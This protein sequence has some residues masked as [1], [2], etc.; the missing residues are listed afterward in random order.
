MNLLIRADASVAIGT[1]HVMRCLALAQAW[2]DAGG[3]AAFAMAET[4]PAIGKRL[5]SEG[6]EIFRVA[7]DSGEKDDASQTIGLGRQ[8]G[9]RWIVVDGYQFSDEYQCVLKDAG[10]KVLFLDDYGH[11]NHYY[12]DLVLNQNVHADEAMYQSR[13]PHTRLL[14]GTRFCLLRRE[15][16]QWREWKRVI[17]PQVRK[18]LVSM[19]GSDA[20]NVTSK[21]LPALKSIQAEVIA[22]AGGSNPH[23]ESLEREAKSDVGFRLLKDVENMPALM[24]WAD[25]AVVAAGSICWEICVTGL[26]SILVVTASNQKDVAETLAR[27]EA[28]LALDSRTNDMAVSMPPLLRKLADSDSFRQSLS[29]KARE[30]V[31]IDGAARVASILR[32]LP[33]S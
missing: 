7:S 33:H 29:S 21:V 12:A 2:Q 14:L 19:G 6:C 18:I 20:G 26:P 23:V 17:S 16:L 28:A 5:K 15:F 24:A 4:T 1:G 27:A 10:F 25:V 13:T 11:A 8:V 31:D 3:K 30:L 32:E 22:V 9:A